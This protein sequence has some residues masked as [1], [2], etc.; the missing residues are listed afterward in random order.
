MYAALYT[1][2]I[3]VGTASTCQAPHGLT[4]SLSRQNCVEE[5]WL[6]RAFD[7]SKRVVCVQPDPMG[8]FAPSDVIDSAELRQQERAN[9]PSVTAED[10]P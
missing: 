4:P 9:A 3:C 5:M 8:G 7:H 2:I 6:T 10:R 1:L